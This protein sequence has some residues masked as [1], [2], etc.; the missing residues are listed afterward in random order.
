[1]IQFS[2]LKRG[3]LG[4]FRLGYKFEILDRQSNGWAETLEILPIQVL[5]PIKL[6]EE[7]KKYYFSFNLIR[8]SYSFKKNNKK[9]KN[10]THK[11]PPKKPQPQQNQQQQ[12]TQKD[13]NKNQKTQNKK[14]VCQ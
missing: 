4:C 1:M 9:T 12:Q 5:L 10:K 6:G 7:S 11:K 2:S 3:E 14:K 13:H 8:K